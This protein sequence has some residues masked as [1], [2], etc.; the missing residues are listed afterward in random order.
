MA[1]P[2]Y[3]PVPWLLSCM[4]VM[5]LT[6]SCSTG[7]RSSANLQ[8]TK[9]R[10]RYLEP[11]WGPGVAQSPINILTSRA[12]KGQEQVVLHYGNSEERVVNLGHTIEVDLEAGN[13]VMDDGE[14]YVLRQFHFHTPSEHLIDGITFPMEMH[15]VHTQEDDPNRYLVMAILFKEGS[16]SRF[17]DSFLDQVP[18]MAGTESPAGH[19]DLTGVLDP[20]D[21]FYKYQGS[22]TTPPYSE[23]VRWFV[24]KKI[25]Q[26]SPEQ[27]ELIH[28]LEGDNARHIQS[29]RERA[30]EDI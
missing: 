15:L 6:S 4:V 3:V 30:V 7:S 20:A 14:R 28:R 29:Y 25:H 5:A 24:S 9:T 26:A 13:W 19:I 8:P 10:A 21:G 23:T 2:A 18:K 11:E 17:L 16:T 27:V 22:L 12:H 1:R